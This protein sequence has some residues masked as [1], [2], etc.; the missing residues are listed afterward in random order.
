MA[1]TTTVPPLVY[2]FF[3]Q[4]ALRGH[5]SLSRVVATCLQAEYRRHSTV[6][7]LVSHIQDPG[8]T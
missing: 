1:V 6:V 2:D 4:Q 3:C 5:V 8:E 7:F